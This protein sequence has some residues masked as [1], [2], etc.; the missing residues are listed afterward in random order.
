M[1]LAKR[2][3]K[4]YD[5]LYGLRQYHEIVKYS[6]QGYDKQGIYT[7][8]EWTDISDIGKEFNGRFLQEEEYLRVENSYIQCAKEIV[9]KS[10]CS[11]LTIG[12]IEKSSRSKRFSKYRYKARIYPLEFENLLKYMLRNDI[13][14]HLVNLRKRVGIYIGYDYYMRVRTPLDDDALNTI[15]SSQELYLD[16]RSDKYDYLRE[17]KDM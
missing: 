1:E 12:Y 2:I 11:Y 9:L 8:D 4:M 14:C 6:P 5:S 7:F 3:T 16:P 13:Y 10:G 17:S 15:V